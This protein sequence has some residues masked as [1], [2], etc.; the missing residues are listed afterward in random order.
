MVKKLVILTVLVIGVLWGMGYDFGEL[1]D[2]ILGAADSNADELT[3][4]AGPADWGD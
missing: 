4:R 2:D 1:K 3:G